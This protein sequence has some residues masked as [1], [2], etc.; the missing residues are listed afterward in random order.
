M[1]PQEAPKLDPVVVPV[2][3][4]KVVENK[5]NVIEKIDRDRPRDRSERRRHE[6]KGRKHMTEAEKSIL[7]LRKREEMQRKKWEKFNRNKDTVI[8]PLGMHSA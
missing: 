7:H 2:T 6:E 5:V 3:P 4:G 1:E 8:D